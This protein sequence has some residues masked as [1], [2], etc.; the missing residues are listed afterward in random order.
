MADIKILDCTLRDGGYVNHWDFKYNTICGIARHLVCAKLDFI[1]CGFL[2]SIAYN[3]NKSLFSDIKQLEN[4]I[5]E[6]GADQKY[7][8]MMNFGEYD[9]RNLQFCT[10]KN[11]FLRIVF[12]KNEY[13]DAVEYCRKLIEKGYRIFVNPMHTNTYSPDEF[14]ELINSVNEIRPYGLTIVDTIGAMTREDIFN[15]FNLIHEKLDKGIALCFHSHNNLQLSFSN[16]Q[17]L[18]DICDNRELIIDSTLFGIGR[19]AGNLCTELL[20]RYI[21]QKY[22]GNYNIEPVLNAIDKYINPIFKNTPWGYSVPYY[23]TAINGCHPNY[24]AY[25]ISHKELTVEQMNRF[26]QSIPDE[27]KSIFN[28]DIFKDNLHLFLQ[29]EH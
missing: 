11:L 3:Q 1:E 15:F 26:L 19:G 10:N 18:I 8:L 13:K 29:Q 9:I 12:K 25:M 5:P 20:V 24:A 2:K 7:T 16:A 6:L 22:A 21:N 27:Y 14:T 4:I 28:E 17:Y 23:L